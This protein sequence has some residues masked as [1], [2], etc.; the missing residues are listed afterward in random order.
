MLNRDAVYVVVLSVSLLVLAALAMF[1]VAVAAG[2][3]NCL[4]LDNSL[5]PAR[6]TALNRA[7]QH[8]HRLDC[9]VCTHISHRKCV[10]RARSAAVTSLEEPTTSS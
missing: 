6:S 4:C 5:Q 9:D 3:R 7:F 2:L 1:A 10:T 8:R